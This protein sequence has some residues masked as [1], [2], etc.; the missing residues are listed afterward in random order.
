MSTTNTTAETTTPNI[1]RRRL[2]SLVGAGYLA[3]MCWFSYLVIFYDFT[4]TN[5]FLFCL[6]LCAVSFA[7]LS[8]MLYSRFQILTRCRKAPKRAP[9]RS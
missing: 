6:T 3:L 5:K 8:A 1:W 2:V 4:A 7:A 9:R